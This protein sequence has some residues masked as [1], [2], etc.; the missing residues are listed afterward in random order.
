MDLEPLNTTKMDSVFEYNDP[1]KHTEIKRIC[2]LNENQFICTT[3]QRKNHKDPVG[4]IKI[5]SLNN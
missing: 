2:Q 1:E 4:K 3:M 5:Y